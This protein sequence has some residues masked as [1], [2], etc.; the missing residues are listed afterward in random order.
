MDAVKIGK[1]ICERRNDLGYTQD[2]LA[3][4]LNVTNKAVSKWECGLGIPDVTL[5]EPL[6]KELNVSVLE[7]MHGEFIDNSD[8]LKREDVEVLL[9]TEF[10]I[11]K[12]NS[13][14]RKIIL[15]IISLMLLS[16]FLFYIINNFDHIY[17]TF[18]EKGYSEIFRFGSFGFISFDEFYNLLYVP[19]TITFDIF[20]KS[21]IINSIISILISIL[22][23]NK[24][25]SKKKYIRTTII[26]NV[27]LEFLKWIFAFMSFDGDDIIIRI[28]VGLIVLSIYIRLKK[29]KSNQ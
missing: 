3:N 19:N 27:I 24:V 29:Y 20:I 17:R 23:I 22:L 26:L 18:F 7:L 13:K 1:F 16:I 12:K 28:I 11:E 9:E 21:I 4:K 25:K 5:F 8:K 14:Y 6:A 10:E 2:E 15:L